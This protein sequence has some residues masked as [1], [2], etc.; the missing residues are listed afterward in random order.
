MSLVIP[1]NI[2]S[3][4]VQP[5]IRKMC[6]AVRNWL[7]VKHFHPFPKDPFRLF[8]WRQS[9]YCVLYG[10]L[11]IERCGAES[12]NSDQRSRK[13]GLSSKD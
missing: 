13:S 11:P 6:P 10:M 2:P 12:S 1:E 8:L 4:A 7:L 5:P 3:S 9:E